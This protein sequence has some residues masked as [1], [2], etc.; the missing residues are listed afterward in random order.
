MERGAIINRPFLVTKVVAKIV[1]KYV[2][3]KIRG[4]YNDK[5]RDSSKQGIG[6]VIY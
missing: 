1:I 5:S 3:Y 4:D 2:K 6:A